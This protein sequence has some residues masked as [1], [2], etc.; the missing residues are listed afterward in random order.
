MINV[1]VF[2]NIFSVQFMLLLILLI[3]LQIRQS[4]YIKY[5]PELPIPLG[6]LA[7]V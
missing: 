3:V 2:K 5:F 6:S 4:N 1:I 7:L